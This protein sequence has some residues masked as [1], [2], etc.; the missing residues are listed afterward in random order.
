MEYL[1]LLKQE[2]GMI[3]NEVIEIALFGLGGITWG[4]AWSLSSTQRQKIVEKLNEY[5]K[6]KS[7]DLTEYL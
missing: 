3:E 6:K 4:E 7:G 1:E 2:E 5:Y